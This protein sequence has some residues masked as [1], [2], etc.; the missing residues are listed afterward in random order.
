MY[1]SDFRP[2]SFEFGGNPLI[3]TE[4]G[5]KVNK[6]EIVAGDTSY[7]TGDRKSLISLTS[8]YK[9]EGG[10]LNNL[11]D[12][13][14][15][16]LEIKVKDNTPNGNFIYFQFDTP[17]CFNSI[18]I[19]AKEFQ[20]TPNIIFYC[21]TNNIE[22]EYLCEMQWIDKDTVHTIPFDM[23]YGSF[24]YF[25]FGSLS[26][27][28]SIKGKL[29]KLKFNIIDNPLIEP[30]L[31]RET[32]TGV[33]N[34]EHEDIA[35]FDVQGNKKVSFLISNSS[36]TA[37]NGTVSDHYEV[38]SYTGER[39][40][41]DTII[42]GSLVMNTFLDVKSSIFCSG[43]ISSH[44]MSASN[45]MAVKG[46]IY[47]GDDTGTPGRIKMFDTGADEWVDFVINDK[48]IYLDGQEFNGGGGVAID[49]NASSDTTVYSSNKLVA[50]MGDKADS[51]LVTTNTNNIGIL[52][53]DVD[54]DGSVDKK[55]KVV[56]DRILTDVPVDAV[57]TDT[58]YEGSKG[59]TAERPTTKLFVGQYYYD[60]TEDVPTW[61][62][63]IDWT[64]A[65][66]TV[67]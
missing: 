21:S 23:P 30:L 16:W 1:L 34:F 20:Y 67:I 10:S 13:K 56:N 58:N 35:D 6:Q 48:N 38:M 9:I 40:S 63:G 5:I 54:T 31:E 22:W 2:V 32:T 36:I 65:D 11:I 3:M 64:K 24:K 59:S 45:D 61:Y 50:L 43:G 39:V 26:E 7:N 49:D 42:P 44:N 29:K 14:N 15:N 46:I 4:T 53:S 25:K 47:A 12:G 66:G 57:F 8:T 51:T 28:D 62:N 52:N 17:Q 55:I 60:D 27:D 41:N 18:S 33:I 37:T 19:Q